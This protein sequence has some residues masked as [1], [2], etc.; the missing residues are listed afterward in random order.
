MVGI[1]FSTSSIA[2]IGNFWF[3]QKKSLIGDVISHALLPGVCVAFLCAQSIAEPYLTIG[4]FIAGS[5]ALFILDKIVFHSKVKQDGAMA[6]IVSCF[7]GTGFFLL[8]YIQ[9]GG[10][11]NQSRLKNLLFGHAAT[12]VREDIFVFICLAC[13]LMVITSLFFKSFSLISFDPLFSEAIG[14]PVGRL[15]LL[16]QFL[17]ILTIIIGVK[18][19]GVLLIATTLTLPAASAYFWT[20][21]LWIMVFISAL[22]ASLSSI[23]GTLFSYYISDL[24]TGPCIVM[25]M[26]FCAVFSFLLAPKK[27][28]VYRRY[29]GYRYGQKVA[30]EN[31]L[32]I[33]YELGEKDKDYYGER[34][35]EGLSAER[36]MSARVVKGVLGKLVQK[37]WVRKKT[38]ASWVLTSTGK[39]EAARIYN[40]HILWEAYLVHYVNIQS[41]HV[42]DDAESIE[43][44]ITPD[45]EAELRAILKM[46]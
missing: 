17:T 19:I 15:N 23:L 39:V 34:S 18:S 22:I 10:S 25:S 27:G 24:P 14:Y 21:R 43:H 35:L 2:I 11:E 28:W 44:V 41:D 20:N 32:K 45:L 31:V 12:L 42:H 4:A 6:F 13:L 30:M 29:M 16:L 1:S 40:L 3:L 38:G 37:G 7:L 36:F 5:L 46:N 8:T 9:Q 33:F 26:V